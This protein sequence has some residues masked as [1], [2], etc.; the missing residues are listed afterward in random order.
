MTMSEIRTD[1]YGY[2]DRS[3]LVSAAT[4]C[5]LLLSDATHAY[6]YDDSGNRII[7]FDLGTNRAY[8]ANSLNQYMQITNFCESAPLGE[9]FHPQFDADGNQTLVKTGSGVWSVAYNGENRPILWNCIQSCNPAV[10]NN[11]AI[12]MTYDRLGRRIACNE[13]CF[14][15]DGYLQISRH[16]MDGDSDGQL[17]V[18]DPTETS[19]TRPLAW[20]RGVNVAYYTHDGDDKD[21]SEVVSSGGDVVAHY[22]Y[23]PFGAVTFRSGTDSYENPWRFSSEYADDDIVLS[24]Y[25]YRHYD[26]QAGRWLARDPIDYG[27][28]FHEYI[29]MGNNTLGRVDELGMDS[30]KPKARRRGRRGRQS[31]SERCKAAVAESKKTGDWERDA[32]V[33]EQIKGLK[34]RIRA[35]NCTFHAECGCCVQDDD[36]KYRDATTT[37]KDR[38]S[39]ADI[40]LCTN[41]SYRAQTDYAVALLHE[42]IHAYDHCRQNIKNFTC[43]QRACSEISAYSQCGVCK[44][45]GSARLPE[46]KEEDCIIRMSKASIQG[47]YKC[48][49]EDED[50]DSILN[51]QFWKTKECLDKDA[52]LRIKERKKRENKMRGRGVR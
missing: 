16:R 11:Q 14:V 21:I 8:T 24:Y 18:W 27:T 52:R 5:G 33:N 31:Q 34:Q 12:A 32:E 10:T 17:F 50:I 49:K 41:G 44:D 4:K 42:L 46:E 25:N 39:H 23:A 45:G 3:E 36:G 28:Y 2:N 30:A 1:V 51:D 22:E 19:A 6:R 47:K 26:P 15:Y 37:A 7:S 38:A 20:V 35:R 13:L 48:P 43:E 40:V 29:M 9:D